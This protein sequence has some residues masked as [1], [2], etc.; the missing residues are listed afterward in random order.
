MFACTQASAADCPGTSQQRGGEPR[1]Q[2]SGSA[3]KDPPAGPSRE[4]GESYVL[5]SLRNRC[6]EAEQRL[7]VV[8]AAADVAI[9]K[10]KLAVEGEEFL[11][12]ELAKM[13]RD[14]L[15]E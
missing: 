15:C 4:E 6:K 2:S 12:G 13:S 5:T 8:Q 1:E 14:L 7:K 3:P 9:S 10:E 11:M